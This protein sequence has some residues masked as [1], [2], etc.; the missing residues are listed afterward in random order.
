MPLRRSVLRFLLGTSGSPH[1]QQFLRG[2]ASTLAYR[3]EDNVPFG[4][5][6]EA[7]AFI[8]RAPFGRIKAKAVARGSGRGA[9]VEITKTKE[10]YEKRVREY[11]EVKSEVAVLRALSGSNSYSQVARSGVASVGGG[12]GATAA[13]GG[14]GAGSI[15]RPLSTVSGNVGA[16]RVAAAGARKGCVGRRAGAEVVDLC[17]SP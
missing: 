7:R 1:I 10:D 17:D 13:A 8:S 2:P 6:A 9:Y 3:G 16:S 12:G 11:A 15:G 4:R 14:S 5:I